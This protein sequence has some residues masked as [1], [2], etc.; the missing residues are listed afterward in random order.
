MPKFVRITELDGKVHWVNL[1]HVRLLTEEPATPKRPARTTV[2][3][4][5]SWV[6]RIIAVT[7]S[8]EDILGQ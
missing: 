8:P 4:D 6:E 3:I 7:Q 1:E 2:H 5:S